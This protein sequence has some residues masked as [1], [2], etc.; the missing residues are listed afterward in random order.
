MSTTK[1]STLSLV[2][3][4][5]TVLSVCV[6]CSSDT[7]DSGVI[8]IAI[9]G[10]MTGEDAAYGTASRDGAHLAIKEW[11]A[12]GGVSGM[13]IESVVEDS[14]CD[15]DTARAAATKL[16]ETGIHYIIGEICSGASIP[17]SEVANQNQT[18]QVTPISTN[19]QV[20]VNS[21]GSVK[22]FVFRACFIDPFQGKVAASFALDSLSATK[23]FILLD[24]DNAYSKGLAEVFE[25]SFT[26]GGGT[27]AG[28]EKYT[29]DATDFAEI[30]EKIKT[31]APDIIYLPDYYSVVNLVTE[32]AKAKNINIPFLGGDGWDSSDL[33]LTTADGSYFTTHFSSE[34]TRP[35]VQEFVTKYQNEY[36]SVPT[37]DGVLGYDATNMLLTAIEQVGSDDPVKVKDALATISFDGVTGNISFDAK[38][39]PVK[40]AVV[41]QVKD[42][43]IQFVASV[44]P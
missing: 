25:A 29:E 28:K 43:K 39:N 17:I 11:N 44:A 37:A 2:L 30:L 41:L 40:S 36:G 10:P 1:L 38:H 7:E 22:D 13:T 27:V 15:G 12:K 8:K 42:G 3:L 33:N 21:D 23:A 18:V 9:M 31:A 19:E 26:E 20:T 32:Q 34:D 35:I 4:I 14:Q 24:E 5:A 6:S 16:I